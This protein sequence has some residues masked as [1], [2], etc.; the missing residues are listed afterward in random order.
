MSQFIGVGGCIGYTVFTCAIFHWGAIGGFLM[1]L[2]RLLCLINKPMEIKTLMTIGLAIAFCVTIN[3]VVL[4]NN[5]TPW[6]LNPFFAFC[7]DKSS[8]NTNQFDDDDDN[9]SSDKILRAL[10]I[11]VAQTLLLAE[12]CIYAYI[13]RDLWKYDEKYYRN[14]TITPQM[15]KEKNVI[16][17]RGQI[18]TFLIESA[19]VM[20]FF[21]SV[22]ISGMSDN[23]SYVPFMIVI[24]PSI[25]PISQ[26]LTSHEIRRDV[27]SKFD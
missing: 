6:E 8:P 23:T 7:T 2:Y 25:V 14:K 18:S 3:I 15:R 21:T 4:Y 16:T 17:L 27:K 24:V 26:L 19:T 1:A 9:G 5:F 22:L 11:F 12:L 20:F 10:N 13:V